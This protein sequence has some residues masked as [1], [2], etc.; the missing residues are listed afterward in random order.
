MPIDSL[1]RSDIAFAQLAGLGLQD[2][3]QHYAPYAERRDQVLAHSLPLEL[4]ADLP[5]KSVSAIDAVLSHSG[6]GRDNICYLAATTKRATLTVL[7]DGKTGD[8]L[9]LMAVDPMTLSARRRMP[10]PATL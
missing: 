9:G 10:T 7:I 8:I 6:H 5:G 3:P 2:L 4:A 1:E